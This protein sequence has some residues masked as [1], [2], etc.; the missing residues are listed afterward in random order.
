MSGV[1]ADN[2]TQDLIFANSADAPIEITSGGFSASF[3]IGSPDAVIAVEGPD[4]PQT[5]SDDFFRTVVDSV[6]GSIAPERAEL[7]ESLNQAIDQVTDGT[8]EG[9]IVKVIHIIDDAEVTI[10]GSGSGD[11]VVALA[12]NDA[13]GG[14]VVDGLDKVIVAGNGAVTVIGDTDTS[15]SG[16]L[17]DQA[18]T[19]GDGNDTIFG[20]AGNDT[21]TGGAGNDT[22]GF[23]GGEGTTTTITDFS[24]GDTFHMEMEGV[25]S[26]NDLVASVASVD[27][28]GG[29]FTATFQ[30][31]STITL[32]GVSPEEITADLFTFN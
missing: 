27:T 1:G 17:R 25:A 2:A 20:G 23:V 14:V 10:H 3:E 18:I 28:S 5:A 26:W 16:D 9:A 6:V 11:E 4:G 13:E 32:V 21:I 12:I 29:N 8:G 30:D 15:I 24:A 22:F 7:N 31:G 19:G